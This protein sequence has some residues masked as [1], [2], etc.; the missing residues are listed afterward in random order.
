MNDANSTNLNVF[1]Q[2]ELVGRVVTVD[3]VSIRFSYAPDWLKNQK[4]FPLSVSLPLRGGFSDEAANN[5]FVNLLPEENVRRRTCA[6]LGISDG[7]NFELLKR[8]G[9]ECAGAITIL[10][11]EQPPDKLHEEKS[12]YEAITTEQLQRWSR[13]VENVFAEVAGS[14]KVRLSLAGAQD[15]LPVLQ[16][17]EKFYL[18]KN[19]SPSSHIMKFPST[20]FKHLP[21]NEVFTTWLAGSIG[22][23]TAKVKLLM[24]DLPEGKQ[25]RIALIERYDRLTEN[26]K[27]KRLHQED[28]CQALGLHPAQKYEKEGGPT[29][30]D[31]AKLIR[32]HCTIPAIELE[33]LVRWSVFN[34]LCHNAD[35]HGKNI[36]FLFAE[37]GRTTVAPFY[38]L[39]C[40]K[41]YE[42]IDEDLAMKIGGQS[43]PGAIS[44]RSLETFASEIEVSAKLVKTITKESALR[45][46]KNL[47]AQSALFEAEYGKSP[48]LERIPHIV[49]RLCKRALYALGIG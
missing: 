46:L 29:L 34:W 17:G 38:D 39:V 22:L 49:T 1:Y 3:G 25:N 12:E 15:K 18:A 10:H 7:N 47:P 4:S 20:T 16:E 43:E 32:G 6:K 27:L 19:A 45:L 9:G 11:S 37:D 35:A 28:F 36:S 48:I 33:K 2:D 42:H 40:T 30:A 14:P 24:V 5:F 23:E 8:I 41:N 26:G 13:G 44:Q 31:C 21:E